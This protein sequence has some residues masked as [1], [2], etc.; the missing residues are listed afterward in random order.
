MPLDAAAFTAL[1]LP[2]ISAVC[3]STLH[4]FCCKSPKKKEAG[5]EGMQ[6]TWGLKWLQDFDSRCL[7]GLMLPA[8]CQSKVINPHNQKALKEAAAC[9]SCS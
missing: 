6:S 4:R 7:V 5:A 8:P 2:Q 9:L 1:R 3:S